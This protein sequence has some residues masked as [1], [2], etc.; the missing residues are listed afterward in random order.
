MCKWAHPLDRLATWFW[1]EGCYSSPL[2]PYVIDTEWQI[3]NC[4]ILKVKS[5]KRLNAPS[6]G[7][8]NFMV[9]LICTVKQTGP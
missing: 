3:L 1:R 4:H 2:G 7:I 6:I 8:A 9:R 5:G